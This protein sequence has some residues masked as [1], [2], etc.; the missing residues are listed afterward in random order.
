MF[1]KIKKFVKVK[2]KEEFVEFEP[3]EERKEKITV[4]MEKLGGIVD[5][6]RIARLIMQ[7]SIVFLNTKDLQKRDVQQLQS[8]IQKLKRYCNQY[9]WDI[10]GTEDGYLVVTPKF[11]KI[12]RK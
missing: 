3:E 11:V 8:S 6:D 5:V 10:V 1:E 12:S 9:G 2:K 7:G 4:R